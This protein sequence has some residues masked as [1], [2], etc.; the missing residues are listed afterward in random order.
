MSVLSEITHIT[1]SFSP[2]QEPSGFRRP[3]RSLLLEDDVTYCSA[4]E[5]SSNLVVNLR[6]A[7]KYSILNRIT[8]RVQH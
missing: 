8:R 6:L 3:V 1:Q 5:C 7:V 2:R 4:S